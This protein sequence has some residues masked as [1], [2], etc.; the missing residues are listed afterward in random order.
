MDA[1]VYN[2]SCGAPDLVTKHSKA[3]IWRFV[4]AHF[5]AKLFAVKRPAFAVGRN[6]IVLAEFRLV[7]MLKRDR[8]LKSVAGSGFVKG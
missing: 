8:D 6:V 1:S 7:L 4:H 3:I 5:L 2:E